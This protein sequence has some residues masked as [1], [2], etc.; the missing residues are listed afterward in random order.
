MSQNHPTDSMNEESIKSAPGGYLALGQ[1]GT[2]IYVYG[3]Y[4]RSVEAL[5]PSKTKPDYLKAVV[6]YNWALENHG[7]IITRRDGSTENV[8]KWTELETK[9]RDEC[10]AAGYP[11][12]HRLRKAGVSLDRYNP[13]RL[14]INDRDLFTSTGKVIGRDEIN[15]T[16]YVDSVPLGLSPDAAV[17]TA[18][19]VQTFIDT[20]ESF[21]HASKDGAKLL[22]GWVAM[23]ATAGAQEVRTHAWVSGKTG[24]GKTVTHEFIKGIL[25]GSARSGTGS[26]SAAAVRQDLRG[27][28]VS[29]L[30]DEAEGNDIS[31]EIQ[32]IIELSR[33]TYTGES[34]I[35]RGT[36]DQ[37]AVG[38]VQRTPFLFTMINMPALAAADANRSISIE[39]NPVPPNT[40]TPELLDPENE[41]KVEVLGIKIRMLVIKRWAVYRDALKVVRAQLEAQGLTKRSA[42]TLAPLVAGYWILLHKERL[43]EE[44]TEALLSEFDISAQAEIDASSD[45]ADCLERLL[46][47]RII[48]GSERIVVSDLI[49]SALRERDFKK[50]TPKPATDLLNQNGL[51]IVSSAGNG[52]MLGVATS[53]HNEELKYL[54]RDTPWANGGWATIL[55][56][57]KGASKRTSVRFGQGRNRTGIHVPIPDEILRVA[58][59]HIE[60]VK[61]DLDAANVA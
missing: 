36:A 47:S 34:P 5:A 28:D 51:A 9:I 30:F 18:A 49:I 7:T 25:G 31:G 24:S 56:R 38:Y 19:D 35:K 41:A 46:D 57:V 20:L 53:Q 52:Y 15:D 55:G 21:R 10:R 13:E 48:N 44:Q 23:A 59:A 16:L 11:K 58:K 37:K 39:L 6:G 32:K 29:Y 42:K 33:Q 2:T 8:V 43:T 1:D 61:C 12:L 3:E 17:A 54:F 4:S 45:E 60:P 50:S 40:P 22:A 26:T 14:L 27:D